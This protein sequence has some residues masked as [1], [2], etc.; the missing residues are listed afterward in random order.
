MTAPTNSPDSDSITVPSNST[1]EGEGITGT[2]G[3]RCGELPTNISWKQVK[4][5]NS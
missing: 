3:R 5:D 2:G 1:S 4:L